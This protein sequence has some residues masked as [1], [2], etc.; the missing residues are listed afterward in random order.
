MPPSL[1]GREPPIW[2][3]RTTF[4]SFNAVGSGG[5]RD[6]WPGAVLLGCAG[7]SA[8]LLAQA[9]SLAGGTLSAPG[10]ATHLSVLTLTFLVAILGAGMALTFAVWRRRPTA[11][12]R[13]TF[14]V[15]AW[16][17]RAVALLVPVGVV[18]VQFTRLVDP[19][20][21]AHAL[22]AGA[23]RGAVIVGTVVFLVPMCVLVW[24]LLGRLV[25]WM[26]GVEGNVGGA[27]V[28]GRLQRL[29]R[30]VNHPLLVGSVVLAL[31]AA[32]LLP[33]QLIDRAPPAAIQT[34]LE[35]LMEQQQQP[36]TQLVLVAALAGAA[37]LWGW[38]VQARD[39][40]HELD[41]QSSRISRLWQASDAGG[42]A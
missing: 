5:A 27:R 22:V 25:T 19:Y 20:G 29:F 26:M 28:E 12:A 32:F 15:M 34:P 38:R 8:W 9:W 2:N 30:L 11:T 16:S 1:R 35:R 40:T 41:P 6:R 21:P 14:T 23:F 31:V 3:L 24:V 42:P 18:G 7:G 17:M 13:Q 37:A 36:M 4:M 10:L 33:V 39:L